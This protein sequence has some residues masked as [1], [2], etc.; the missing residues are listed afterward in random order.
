MLVM[1][2]ED[3]SKRHIVSQSQGVVFY[4]VPHQGC[5][6]ADYSL[7]PAAYLLYPSV[8]VRELRL[9]KRIM[10]LVIYEIPFRTIGR[11]ISK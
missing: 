2:N 1:A 4:S 10:L 9:G 11:A 8:E 3:A 7:R 5:S 6:L